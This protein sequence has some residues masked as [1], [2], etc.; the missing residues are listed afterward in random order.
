MTVFPCTRATAP[1]EL[2]EYLASV[3]AAV[4]AEGRTY[5]QMGEITTE[6]F[7]DYFFAEDCF[8]GLLDVANEGI[9]ASGVN[10]LDREAG[11]G[12]EKVRAGRSWEEAVLGMFCE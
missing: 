11:Y 8:V 5:P 2:V 1:P 4:V 12:L 6:T 9:R 7:A 10:G 3:F